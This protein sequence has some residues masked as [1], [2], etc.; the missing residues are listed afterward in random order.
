M[1]MV[2]AALLNNHG[3][4]ALLHSMKAADADL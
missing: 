4:N 3:P 1:W 2:N